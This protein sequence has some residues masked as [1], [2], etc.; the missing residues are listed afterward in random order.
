MERALQSAALPAH[1]TAQSR[2]YA[3]VRDAG[4]A[5]LVATAKG[6]LLTMGRTVVIEAG[7]STADIVSAFVH[8]SVLMREATTPWTEDAMDRRAVTH[9]LIGMLTVREMLLFFV[10]HERHHLRGVQAR[11]G[12][13]GSG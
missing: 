4:A 8:A 5:A 10:V 12:A 13:G 1:P 11:V 9:P 2:S 6:K 3:E 7:S